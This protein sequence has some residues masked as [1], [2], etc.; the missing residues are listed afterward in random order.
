MTAESTPIF[1]SKAS[2]FSFFQDL[3]SY[4]TEN[5]S[6]PQILRKSFAPNF[7]NLKYVAVF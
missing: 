5:A 1:A 3:T 4:T 7:K 6:K 2:F